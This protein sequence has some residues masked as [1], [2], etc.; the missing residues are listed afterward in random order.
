MKTY[1]VSLR[2]TTYKTHQVNASSEEELKAKVAE[3]SLEC[4]GWN[5]GSVDLNY[6]FEMK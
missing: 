2:F 4:E 5:L 6:F 1:E 3:F